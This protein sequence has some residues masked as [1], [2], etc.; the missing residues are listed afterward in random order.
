MRIKLD[1]NMP[2]GLAGLLRSLGHDVHTVGDE[3]LVGEPD[4]AIWDAVTR[5]SR[6]LI[7]QD[8]DFSDARQFVL[9][10][11]P[12]ILLVRLQDPGREALREAVVK[13]FADGTALTWERCFVVL[14][15]LKA[16]VRRPP[17]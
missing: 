13:M 7:T 10:N 4:T 1:E 8:L 12:G 5:E 6:F 9:G 16:R 2:A 15:E 14:T 11:H 3:G 17:S